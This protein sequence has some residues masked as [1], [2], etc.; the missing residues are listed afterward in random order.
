VAWS[1]PA[2]AAEPLLYALSAE[3]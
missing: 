2:D 1:F 3:G